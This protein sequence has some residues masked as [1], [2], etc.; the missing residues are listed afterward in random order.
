MRGFV[1]AQPA[2]QQPARL[3]PAQKQHAIPRLMKRHQELVEFDPN[4]VERSSEPRVLALGQALDRT[5]IEIF[6]SDTVDYDRYKTI[7]E[8]G[9]TW[10][11]GEELP[12]STTR[13]YLEE[14]K[15]KAIAVLQGIIDGFREDVEEFDSPQRGALAINSK[16]KQI[17]IVHGH[18]DGVREA[19]ARFIRDI[20]FV[21]IILHERATEGRTVIEK[22]EAHGDVGFAVV[23]L[24]PDDEGCQKGGTPGPRARQTSSW[25]WA[26][27]SA[28]LVAIACV[29]LSA[30]ILKFRPTSAVWC[31]SRLM[32]PAAG[33]RS[34]VESLRQ[35]ATQSFGTR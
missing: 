4:T 27:L 12:I 14:D 28:A 9:K 22:V 26:T 30:V 25:S 31:T 8:F 23:L 34:W 10:S 2:P 7:N 1:S 6:G 35:S 5:L 13:K 18:D 11:F 32:L 33:N 29:H 17:F 21:P 20:G 19:V 24:T 16:S 15:A 3:T